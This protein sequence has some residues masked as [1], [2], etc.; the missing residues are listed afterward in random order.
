MSG[1]LGELLRTFLDSHLATHRV[2]ADE[3]RILRALARC[4]TEDLGWTEY[5]CEDCDT[6]ECVLRG[7]GRV[8]GFAH[9]ARFWSHLPTSDQH[10]CTE[11][12]GWTEYQCED[13]D[14]VECV[15]RGC[16]RVKGFAHA[17]RFW[18]DLPTS[19]QHVLRLRAPI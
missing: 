5:Q 15:L 18:G 9:A 3:R 8:K 12:L 13:C 16:G 14:T 6:V 4:G 1:E 10:V 7:C 19:D 2:P 11:D 17:A